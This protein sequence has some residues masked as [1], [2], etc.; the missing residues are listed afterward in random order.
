[1][2][3]KIPDVKAEVIPDGELL[4]SAIGV[5]VGEELGLPV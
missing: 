5:L 4:G 3:K 2:G 1:L